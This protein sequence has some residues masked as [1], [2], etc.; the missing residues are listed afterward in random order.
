MLFL[1]AK[2]QFDRIFAEGLSD[3]SEWRLRRRTVRALTSARFLE[4]ARRKMQSFGFLGTPLLKE[5]NNNNG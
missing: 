4:Y 2:G 5:R 1:P 3:L